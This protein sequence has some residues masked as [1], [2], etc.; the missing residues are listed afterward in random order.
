M[1]MAQALE[2]REE[3]M[4]GYAAAL[5]VQHSDGRVLLLGFRPQWRGQPFGTFKILF[6][7]LLYTDEVA[8]M[9]SLAG[10]VA[11]TAN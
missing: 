1:A 6:N 5:E 10:P 2:E 7:A 3:H 8:A 11:T 4:Q 9:S